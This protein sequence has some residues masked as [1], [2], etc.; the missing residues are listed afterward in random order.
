MFNKLHG[1]HH[2]VIQ[3]ALLVGNVMK[4][5]SVIVDGSG[6]DG[7]VKNTC[8][9]EM[10]QKYMNIPSSDPNLNELNNIIR[11]KLKATVRN[12]YGTI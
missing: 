3:L 11:D 9:I 8:I 5:D 12:S 2:Q 10:V 7:D 4:E 1:D 6:G